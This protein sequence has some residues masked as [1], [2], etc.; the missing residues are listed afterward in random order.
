MIECLQAYL[1]GRVPS[2]LDW[3]LNSA[4]TLLGAELASRWGS[5]RWR[6]ADALFAS[7]TRARL[8]LTAVGTWVGAQLFPFVPSAD[9][10][11][12]RAGLRPAWHV[13]TGQASFSVAQATVYALAALSLSSILPQCLNPHRRSRVLVP[14]F[15]VAV[16]LAKVPIVTRQLSLEAL[17]GVLLG[18]A[19]SWRLSA[20]RPEG[21]VTFL[22]A[23][24]A[25]VLEELRSGPLGSGAQA[26][27]N[28]IPFRNHLT[29]EIVGASDILSGA[30][31]FLA[32]AYVVS[33]WPWFA[34]RRAALGGA[35]LVFSGAMFLEWVQRLLPGRSPDVTDALI[36]V[37]A[38][39]LAWYGV[40]GSGRASSPRPA[41]LGR[42]Q[43]PAPPP[44]H[45]PG[46]H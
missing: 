13:L 40:S 10:S 45:P 9:V 2:I 30:W 20:S 11:N 39:L 26:A 16:L 3:G 29:N 32:L 28:W 14:L 37:A 24:G 19:L 6:G 7:G 15:F 25:F 42:F 1:P 27:F 4:G 36:A 41:P 31:P 38:W 17:F 22:G 12:L 5:V 35:A 44:S 21:M 34:W 8:G 23:L 46:S 18:L 33:G 43:T